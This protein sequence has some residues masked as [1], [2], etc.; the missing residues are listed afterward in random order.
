MPDEKRGEA[1]KAVIQLKPD[2]R[3]SGD[4]LISLCKRELG[5]VKTPKTIEFWDELLRSAVGK[6]LKRDIREKYWQGQWRSV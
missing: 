1:V 3:A 5:S 4:E 6:V 2:H